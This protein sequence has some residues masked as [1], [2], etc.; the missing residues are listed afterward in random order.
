M[1]VT[2]ERWAEPS[3]ICT[4]LT[5]GGPDGRIHNSLPWTPSLVTKYSAPFTTA[6][7][8]AEKPPGAQPML[9]GLMSATMRVPAA[10]PSL[11]HSSA[12]WT[13]SLAEKYSVP[14]TLVRDVGYDPTL[15]GLISLTMSVPAVV[16]LLFHSSVPCVPS[17]A[18]RN[19]VPLTLVRLK[20]FELP[21][22]ALMSLT[23]AVP[24]AVPSLFHNSS[25]CVPSPA[26]K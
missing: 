22:P 24:A 3:L 8:P 14:L 16:P 20:R 15:P 9:L 25:P 11:C 4:P 5:I 18:V 13:P 26:V 17:S 21:L 2:S 12:P 10:V 7:L 23:K 19:N 1:L 6:I